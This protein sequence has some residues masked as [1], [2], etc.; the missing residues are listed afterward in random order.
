MTCLDNFFLRHG[1][2]FSDQLYLRAIPIHNSIF[3]W[4]LL[5]LTVNLK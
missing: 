2:N 4:K 1:V 5:Q 3:H